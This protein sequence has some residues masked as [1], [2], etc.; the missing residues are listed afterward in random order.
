ML[1]ACLFPI[2][3]MAQE[4]AP[5]AD[6]D[7]I[8]AADP[9]PAPAPEPVAEPAPQAPSNEPGDVIANYFMAMGDLVAQNMETPSAL[10]EKFSAYIK[11]NEKAMRNAS[12]AFDAKLSSMK[13]NDAEV[14][15]ETVQ[16]KITPALNKLITLLI[17]FSTR[18]PAESKQ[19]DS[20][21]KI[22]AKYT[23][24]Q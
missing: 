8:P 23:Y 22:D 19:L 24:Q 6:P 21:L 12:K 16:R 2:S 14:Y 7:P 9:A 5:A 11:E 10:V 17:E 1:A 18:Y 15:R 4:P 13:P 20:M 3:A